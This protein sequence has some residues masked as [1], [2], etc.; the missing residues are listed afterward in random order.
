MTEGESHDGKTGLTQTCQQRDPIAGTSPIFF[1]GEIT[2]APISR[3]WIARI[4]QTQCTR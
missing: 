1:Y 3:K 2:Y 4:H